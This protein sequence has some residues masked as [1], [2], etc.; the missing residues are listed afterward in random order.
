MM[1]GDHHQNRMSKI[2]GN[3]SSLKQEISHSHHQCQP[4][5]QQE[6]PCPKQNASG[7]PISKNTPL[8]PVETG[9]MLGNLF[10]GLYDPYC[11]F[12]NYP[13]QPYTQEHALLFQV[14]AYKFATHELNLLLDNNPKNEKNIQLFNQYNDMYQQLLTQYTKQF[15]PLTI[16]HCNPTNQWQWINSPWPWTNK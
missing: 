14:L 1:M 13:L 9:F 6:T 8:F 16:D 12:T 5:T 7:L 4:K 11:G 10:E 3:Q 15:H 2:C